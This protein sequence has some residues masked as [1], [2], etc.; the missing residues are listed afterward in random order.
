MFPNVVTNRLIHNLRKRQ[1]P[2]LCIEFIKQILTNRR[3]RIHF[4]DYVSGTIQIKNGIG[5]GDPLLMILYILYN[6]DLLEIS[7]NTEKDDTIGYVDDIAIIATGKDF[8]EMTKKISHIMTEEEGGIS[9]SKEHNSKFETSK[10]TIMHATK[11]TDHKEGNVTE[12]PVIKIEG[13][14]IKEVDNYKYLGIIIDRPVV[15]CQ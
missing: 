10:S 3:T 6:A 13:H 5:Q 7:G 14:V 9:W 4:D 12:K 11:K 15:C 1:I 2:T 8:A